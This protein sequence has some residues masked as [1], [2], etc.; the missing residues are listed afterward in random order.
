MWFGAATATNLFTGRLTF[1][2]GLLPA[3][4]MA[5]ALQR[6]RPWLAGVLA[7]R[8]P[9][10]PARWRRCSRPWPPPR[11]PSAP[12]RSNATQGRPARAPLP[13]SAAL[14]PVALLSVAFPEGGS[15]PFTLATLWPIP[16]VAI[17]AARALPRQR[18]WMLR[19]GIVLYAARLHRRLR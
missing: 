9:R 17:V 18:E 13:S 19:A 14:L 1:A 3:M 11:T 7:H 12:T 2:F 16:A 5:L 15:E 10:W 4:A 6:D 8:S